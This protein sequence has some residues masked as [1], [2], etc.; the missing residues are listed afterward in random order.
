VKYVN[1]GDILKIAVMPNCAEDV[2]ILLDA[3]RTMK[4][5]YSDCPLIAISMGGKGI[6]SRISGEIFGSDL[7]FGASVKASAPGQIPAGD[8]RKI[9]QLL[10][11]NLKKN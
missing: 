11:C 5:G 3:A 6:V 9:I 10:H 1:D 7:T 8:L 4:E 2:L